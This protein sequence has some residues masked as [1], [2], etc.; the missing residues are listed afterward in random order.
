MFEDRPAAD[1]VGLIGPD[2]FLFAVVDVQGYGR[3]LPAVYAL[4][5]VARIA[6]CRV[7]QLC[8]RVVSGSKGVMFISTPM[9]GWST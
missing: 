7:P 1:F 3:N 8:S 5:E 2:R 9:C 6:C 4:G